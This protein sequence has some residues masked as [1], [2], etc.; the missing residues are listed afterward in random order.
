MSHLFADGTTPDKCPRILLYQ[1]FIALAGAISEISE[2]ETITPDAHHDWVRQRSDVFSQFY[3]IGTTDAKTGMADD[4]IFRLYSLGFATGRDPYI[5]NFSR[6]AC[7]ENGRRMTADYLAAI[8]ELEQDP[9]LP[10]AERSRI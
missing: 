9:N 10:A 4:A 6:D 8:S 5:Y 3:P 7:G 1:P 2:W